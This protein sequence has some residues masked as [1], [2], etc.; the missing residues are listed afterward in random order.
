MLS[1]PK[2]LVGMK[3]TG[4]IKIKDNHFNC[5][6][7][8]GSQVT[9]ILIFFYNTYLSDHEIKPLNDLRE[10]EGANGQSVP[11]MG[12]IEL[13][14]TFPPYIL[15]TTINID[16]LALVIP[17]V[18]QSQLLI[19]VGTNTFDIAYY[20]YFDMPV[21]SACCLRLPSCAQDTI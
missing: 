15:S 13:N 14:M 10:I 12:Y 7:D 5:L 16:T 17:D 18:K 11:Y 3:S 1:L 4:Q 19:L 2:C 21:L 6:L 20:K 9:T 8:T